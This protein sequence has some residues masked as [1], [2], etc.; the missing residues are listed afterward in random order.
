[1]GDRY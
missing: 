1:M